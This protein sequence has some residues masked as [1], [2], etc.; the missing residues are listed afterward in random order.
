MNRGKDQL[1]DKVKED[2]EGFKKRANESRK[3]MYQRKNISPVPQ[4]TPNKEFTFAVR[5]ETLSRIEEDYEEFKKTRTFKFPTWLYGPPKGKLFK[6]EVEDCP[7]FGDKA[8]VEFDSA[9]TAFLSIDMQVDFC[10]LKGYVDVM[11]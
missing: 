6:L 10:G 7:R 1:S 4:T 5:D 2:T 8:F 9:R 3:E 11:G